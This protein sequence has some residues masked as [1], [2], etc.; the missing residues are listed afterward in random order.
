MLLWGE[1]VLMKAK[2]DKANEYSWKSGKHL[3]YRDILE[4]WFSLVTLQDETVLKC[5]VSAELN[6]KN[7][8]IH[9]LT[10][11]HQVTCHSDVC[12]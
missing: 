6:E 8:M 5:I 7:E 1:R 11:L 10:A 12:V 4:A 9:S 3:H 2:Y